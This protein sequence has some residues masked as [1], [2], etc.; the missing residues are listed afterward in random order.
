MFKKVERAQIGEGV[1]W[2]CYTRKR[3]WFSTG[4]SLFY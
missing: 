3:S 1:R 2:F 4:W